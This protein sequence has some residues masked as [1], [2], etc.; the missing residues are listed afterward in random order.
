MWD[1]QLLELSHNRAIAL[2]FPSDEPYGLAQAPLPQ[3]S[4]CTF[5]KLAAEG[6]V[7]YTEASDHFG[8]AVGAYTHGATLP[9][10]QERELSGL[11]DDRQL[12][13]RR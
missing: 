2:T 4:G 1:Q 7:F 13:Q 10:I 6:R 9:E 12:D 5:W 11:I 3:P 8:C